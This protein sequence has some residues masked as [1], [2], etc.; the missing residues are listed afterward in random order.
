M[1]AKHYETREERF[2]APQLYFRHLDR[3]H[4]LSMQIFEVGKPNEDKFYNLR[5]G[6][7]FLEAFLVPVL[8]ENYKKFI[9]KHKKEKPPESYAQGSMAKKFEYLSWLKKW[10]QFLNVYAYS[11]GWY[12]V[13]KKTKFQL[14]GEK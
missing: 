3:L 5:A 10:L 12:G 2:N 8:D 14:E 13:V 1:K 6:I 7:E 4:A 9:E 11:I